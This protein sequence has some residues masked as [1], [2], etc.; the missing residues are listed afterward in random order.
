DDQNIIERNLSGANIIPLVHPSYQDIFDEIEKIKQLDI[1]VFVGHSNTTDTFDDARIYIQP[2]EF[3]TINEIQGALEI[4][5]NKGLKLI[6]FNSCDGLGIVRKLNDLRIDIP[7]VIVMR[8]PIHNYIAQQFL[9]R[10]LGYFSQGNSLDESLRRTRLFLLGLNRRYP[11][12]SWLPLLFYNPN[13]PPL[14]YPPIPIKP[15]NDKPDDPIP[16]WKSLFQSIKLIFDW[17]KSIKKKLLFVILALIVVLIIVFGKNISSIIVPTRQTSTPTSAQIPEL[18]ETLCT[19]KNNSTKIEIFFSCGEKGLLNKE[20]N[21]GTDYFSVQEYQKAIDFFSKNS[22]NPEHLIFKNN[23][24]ILANKDLKAKDILL[25]ALALPIDNKNSYAYDTGKLVMEGVAFQQEQFNKS[26]Q[27]K[28]FI[29]LA[30]DTNDAENNNSDS[31]ALAVAKEIVNRK[32]YAVIGHYGSRVSYKTLNNSYTKSQMPLISFASTATDNKKEYLTNTTK[33]TYF[34]RTPYTVK[35]SVDQLVKYFQNNAV[36]DIIVFYVDGK[37]FSSSFL[38]ELENKNTLKVK[39][40]LNMEKELNIENEIKQIL[41][42]NNAVQKT[43]IALCPDA[44]TVSKTTPTEMTNT[45]ALLKLLKEPQYQQLLVGA[46]NVVSVYPDALNVENIKVAVPWSP[47]SPKNTEEQKKLLT[48]LNNYWPDN[49]KTYQE[50]SMRRALGYDAALVLSESLIDPK[51]QLPLKDGSQLQQ[52]LINRTNP[53]KGITG[54]IVFN[55]GNGNLGSDRR[56]I[57]GKIEDT[58]VLITPNCSSEKC[59]DWKLAE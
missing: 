3:V 54:D 53:F 31:N 2:N 13:T 47:H 48:E 35:E 39:K 1:I 50:A 10:L 21:D 44:F 43:A 15:I 8:E 22:Q 36:T 24:E 18:I 41:E 23:A 25:I 9:N 45:E 57:P 56:V 16:W 33:D 5:K 14:I 38:K 11:N 42:Q 46:C 32:P 49:K 30:N 51:L 17:L 37:L 58:T 34:F 12:A 20:K 27:K 40:R 28:I 4:A 55:D 29:L 59:E 6:V 7:Y 26:N 52:Y 19:P